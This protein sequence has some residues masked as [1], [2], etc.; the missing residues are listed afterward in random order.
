MDERARTCH[1]GGMT[2]FPHAIAL[3][4]LLACAALPHAAAQTGQI[5]AARVYDSTIANAPRLGSE[6]GLR[7][8]V[9]PQTDPA[10]QQALDLQANAAKIALG[11]LGYALNG[12]TTVVLDLDRPT[13]SPGAHLVVRITQASGRVSELRVAGIA[14]GPAAPMRWD[15]PAEQGLAR[16]LQQV[17]LRA[18]PNKFN[19]KAAQ[20]EACRKAAPDVKLPSIIRTAIILDHDLSARPLDVLAR[21]QEGWGAVEAPVSALEFRLRSQFDAPQAADGQLTPL[22]D[23]DGW[24]RY[25]IAPSRD[26]RCARFEFFV[27]RERVDGLD[28]LSGGPRF[29]VGEDGRRLW[30]LAAERID[31][32]SAEY[33]VRRTVTVRAI[34]TDQRVTTVVETIGPNTVRNPVAQVLARRTLVTRSLPKLGAIQAKSVDCRGVETA[35]VGGLAGPG[36]ALRPQ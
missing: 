3:A 4:A 12:A 28:A 23:S 19:P 32:P 10:A 6:R 27:R 29:M 9:A 17:L 1:Q 31:Q 34:T 11:G 33:E 20:A 25:S 16:I 8:V 24:W 36:G 18:P 22:V 13:L 26:P 7:L 30:C 14:T 35:A 5:D 15:D 21:L 2:C